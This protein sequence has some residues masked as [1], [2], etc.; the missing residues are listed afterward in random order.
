MT[1]YT[2]AMIVYAN[3]ISEIETEHRDDSARS[4]PSLFDSESY[5]LRIRCDLGQKE[6][7]L[8]STTNGYKRN[9]KCMRKC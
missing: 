9:N 7:G 6:T 5:R 8:P 2:N 1:L 3:V 4:L